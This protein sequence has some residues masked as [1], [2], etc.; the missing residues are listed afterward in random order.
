MRGGGFDGVALLVEDPGGFEREVGGG[1]LLGSRGHLP[2]EETRFVV[3][4]GM[5]WSEHTSSRVMWDSR[6]CMA[7][8]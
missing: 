7:D 4:T 1:E 5:M 6:T 2:G 3:A 8:L